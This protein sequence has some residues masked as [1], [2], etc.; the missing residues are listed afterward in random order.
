MKFGFGILGLVVLS[1]E[2]DISDEIKIK[3]AIIGKTNKTAGLPIFYGT[4]F[5][6][7]SGVCRIGV[8]LVFLK[9]MAVALKI[10]FQILNSTLKCF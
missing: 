6:G 2:Q 3:A 9:F 7:S 5:G 10:V 1:G 8:G 4:E